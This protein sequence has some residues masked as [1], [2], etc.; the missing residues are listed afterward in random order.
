MPDI[1]DDATLQRLYQDISSSSCADRGAQLQAFCEHTWKRLQSSPLPEESI[2]Q[3]F[4]ALL[5]DDDNLLLARLVIPELR[6]GTPAPSNPLQQN[7]LRQINPQRNSIKILRERPHT[8]D[9]EA[10]RLYE[11]E[12]AVLQDADLYRA[13]MLLY[14]HGPANEAQ[15]EDLQ[16]WLA[17]YPAERS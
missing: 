14:G 15:K 5:K 17:A 10:H 2:L 9:P 12:K 8:R 16:Q 4:A 11:E 1:A 6:L 13:A 7:L 3:D